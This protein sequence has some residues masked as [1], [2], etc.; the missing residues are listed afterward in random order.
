MTMTPK[1]FEDKLKRLLKR[2]TN[3]PEQFHVKADRLIVAL[4]KQLGYKDGAKVFEAANKWY[5]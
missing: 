1:E 2:Y 5:S 4:L 3:N